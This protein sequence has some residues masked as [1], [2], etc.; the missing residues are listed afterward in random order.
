[1]KKKNSAI[2][3]TAHNAALLSGSEIGL[4]SV[5]HGLKIPFSGHFLSLNQG[6]ILSRATIKSKNVKNSKFIPISISNIS[7]LLK[8]LAPAGKKLTPLK[9]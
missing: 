7:S 5:L 2:E 3:T 8:T 4:G 9:K 1:M 6:F